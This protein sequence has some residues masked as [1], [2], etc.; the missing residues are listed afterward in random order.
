MGKKSREKWERRARRN[1]P[2]G[3]SENA[4]LR[5]IEEME[6]HLRDI[7]NGNAW[8]NAAEDLPLATRESHLQDILAFESIDSGPSMFE[9]LQERGLDLPHPDELDEQ[10]CGERILEIL[11]ALSKI[12]VY[13]IGLEEMSPKE[14]YA[15]LWNE[16]LWEGCYVEKRT[17]HS[18]TVIDAAGSTLGNRCRAA[19]GKFLRKRFVN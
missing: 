19:V 7:A 1:T 17:A 15:K 4:Q 10:E 11:L 5:H 16:T 12:Q 2:S 14:A 18:L 8:F 6:N 3:G 9:G 13:I